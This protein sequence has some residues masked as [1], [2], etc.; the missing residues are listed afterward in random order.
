MD[1]KLTLYDVVRVIQDLARS[2]HEVVAV[3]WHMLRTRKLRFARPL[4]SW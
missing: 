2:D 4:L 1:G 3:L